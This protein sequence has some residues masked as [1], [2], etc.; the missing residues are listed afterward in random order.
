MERGPDTESKE[1]YLHS[2]SARDNHLPFYNAVAAVEMSSNFLPFRS[3]G[4]GIEA[5]TSL[6]WVKLVD[7]EYPEHIH[8]E[9][10]RVD[11]AS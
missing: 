7:P 1:W 2:L 5:P 11:S 9:R 3:A 4:V 6:P 8:Q 10:P